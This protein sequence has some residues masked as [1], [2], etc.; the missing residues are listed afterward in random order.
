[1]YARRRCLRRRRS[2]FAF[3]EFQ[4]L[5]E[6]C[7]LSIDLTLNTI[8]VQHEAVSTGNLVVASFTFDSGS[9]GDYSAEIS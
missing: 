1:M 6:R 7:L 8:P 2:T 4:A 9:L 3:L 5:E